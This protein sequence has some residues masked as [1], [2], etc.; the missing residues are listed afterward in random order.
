MLRVLF[1]LFITIPLLELYVLIE[2]GSGI[3][4]FATIALCLLTAAMGGA[5]I[6]MQ[7]LST[8]VDAQRRMAH[9]ELPAD[10]GFHGLLLA[11]SGLLLF[12]PGFIT[13]SIGFLL[14]VPPLRQWLINRFIPISQQQKSD[15]IDVEVIHHD[16]HIP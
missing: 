10:H 14:L 3:G 13:D 1:L 4:G 12:T 2:V 15:I 7:G 9:G 5:L 16:R 6:R 11:L 8:L